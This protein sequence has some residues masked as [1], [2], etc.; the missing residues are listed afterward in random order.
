MNKHL[1][2]DTLWI[3][4]SPLGT[5]LTT[6]IL[7][8][9]T[10]QHTSHQFW[11]AVLNSIIINP[12]KVTII[13]VRAPK[14]LFSCHHSVKFLIKSRKSLLIFDISYL[15]WDLTKTS[16][17]VQPIICTILTS[18]SILDRL[19]NSYGRRN[20]EWVKFPGK[21]KKGGVIIQDDNI[22]W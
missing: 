16:Y 12:C 8:I 5:S 2:V 1:C 11:S 13:F 15:Y 3:Q 17:F 19:I 10:T 4:F 14:I 18:T 21:I 6:S 20:N 22:T 7:T 9:L